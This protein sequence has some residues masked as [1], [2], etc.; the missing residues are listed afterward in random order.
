MEK[1]NDVLD[2]AS[3]LEM[4]SRQAAIANAQARNKQAQQPNDQGVYEIQDCIECG[5]EIGEGRLRAAA[6]NLLCIH[7][8]TLK[9]RSG[10]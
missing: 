4:A 3:E 7:C 6:N 8:A 5:D 1:H 10:R 9:E 2:T